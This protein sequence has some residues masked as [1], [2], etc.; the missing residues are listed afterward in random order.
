MNMRREIGTSS[1]R[2]T[3]NNTERNTTCIK[4]SNVLELNVFSD[5]IIILTASSLRPT[6]LLIISSLHY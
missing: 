2:A 5:I 1:Y 3:L 6:D 4:P